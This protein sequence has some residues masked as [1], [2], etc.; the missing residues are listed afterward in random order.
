MA[1][2]ESF[3]GIRGIYGKELTDSIAV[4]Y[5]YA[6]SQLLGKNKT[7]VIG[8]DTRPSGE[9]IRKE[10][11][12]GLQCQIIDVG[13]ALTPAVQN[14]V[15]TYKADGGIIITASHN[16]PE[17][18][19]FKFLDTDGAVLR[20]KQIEQVIKNY[21]KVKDLN[22]EDFLT[23]HLFKEE[24][25]VK[26]VKKVNAIGD[27]KKFLGFGNLKVKNKIIIDPNGG[28]GIHA[29][30][31]LGDRAVYVN[32][33]E[34]AFKRIVEPNQE[35]LQY[36]T[37][38]IKKHKAA[39]AAGFDCDAD[40]VEVILEDGTLVSGNHLL[41]LIVDHM[42]SESENPKK[43]TVV[44]NDAT[45]YLVKEIAEKHH[46]QWQEVEVGEINVVDAMMLAQSS[47]G[48]EGS[49]GG[50]IIAPSKCRDG[51]QTLLFLLKI[52]EK[53]NT[54][55][56]E[57]VEK[58]PQ[59]YYLKEKVKLKKSFKE[60]KDQIKEYYL[61]KGF[62]AHETGDETG[63][64]KAVKDHAWIWFRQSKTEDKVLRIITDSPDEALAKELMEE[65]KKLVKSSV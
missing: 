14:A 4:R 55:L 45:S 61:N 31:I 11:I 5:A 60:K 58:L 38:E 42:L 21:H 62:I 51:I 10:L 37:K 20:P 1:L 19:G 16:E 56:K 2:V 3:S 8:R 34:G 63:G 44:V 26:E 12:E 48:G 18:N 35:S 22:E 33:K 23:R 46:A 54:S 50:V 13:V 39:F 29:K 47:I 17:Y 43:E 30:E 27:Y 52:L 32:M 24:K 59:Y 65:G 41:A 28:A 15:R 7:V 36:L 53:K 49:N 40:R 9:Q 25:P 57:V 64:L 6:F